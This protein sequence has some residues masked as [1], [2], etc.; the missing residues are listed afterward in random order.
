MVLFVCDDR[1]VRFSL[2][3]QAKGPG[4]QWKNAQA[5]AKAKGAVAAINGGFFTPEGT[6]LGLVVEN[7]KPFGHWN[8][9]TSLTSGVFFVQEGKP[10]LERSSSPS[11]PA[12]TEHLLQTG[13]FLLEKNSVISGLSNKEARPRSFLLWDGRHHWAIGYANSATLAT[14]AKALAQ[15]AVP[16]FKIQSALNLDGGSSSQ[17]WIGPEVKAGPQWHRPLWTKPVRN[18]ILVHKNS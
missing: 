14:L 15:Q 7:K 16:N 6:P 3:D 12:A 4:T 2:A 10:H 8:R 5:A 9:S 17:L 11:P 13:P 1:R 18:F